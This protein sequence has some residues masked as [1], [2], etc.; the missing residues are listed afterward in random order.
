MT[1]VQAPGIRATIDDG[2][3]G[4]GVGGSLKMM[5]PYKITHR[6]LTKKI[7]DK[8]MMEFR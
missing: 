6:L 1:R 8:F 7:A 5:E 2:D 4:L 3:R